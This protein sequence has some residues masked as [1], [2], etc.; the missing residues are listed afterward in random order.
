M[1]RL[2]DSV[3]KIL[4]KMDSTDATTCFAITKIGRMCHSEKLFKYEI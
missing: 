2:S 3:Y 1:K 4:Q